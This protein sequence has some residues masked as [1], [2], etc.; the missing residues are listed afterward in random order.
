[1]KKTLYQI[2]GVDPNASAQDI[3]QAYRQ[4][5]EE[6]S[7]ATIH[8]PNRLVVLQ[9][10]KE[11]LSDT[12]L[13]AAYDASL[14]D[15]A[16]HAHA[17]AHAPVHALAGEAEAPEPTFFQVWGKWVVA[18]AILIGLG[19]W[20][21]KQDTAPPPPRTVPAP[22][23]VPQADEPA[24]QPVQSAE[25]PADQGSAIEQAPPAAAV[26]PQDD[27]PANP[28]LGQ[29]SCHDAI[30]G[31]TARYNFQPDGTLSITATGGQAVKRNYEVSGKALKLTDPQQ[32][33]TFMIEEMTA[34]KMILHTGVEGRREVCER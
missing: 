34:R 29:W 25:T 30:S 6:S 21:A 23:A 12:N 9:Q 15:R 31:R 18:G 2:L 22:Q 1:M 33:S 5:V 13:R 27:A 8:D 17:H 3:A 28:I 24:S 26:E 4:L 11:I 20:W 32:A 19:V 7:V 10:A 16:E 14:A